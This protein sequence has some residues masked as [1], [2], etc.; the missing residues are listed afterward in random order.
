MLV[1]SQT[2]DAFL[3]YRLLSGDQEVWRMWFLVYPTGAS[4][5]ETLKE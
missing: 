2:P 5:I 4:E 1:D 3:P